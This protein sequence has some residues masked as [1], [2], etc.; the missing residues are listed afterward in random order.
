MKHGTQVQDMTRGSCM[1]HLLRFAFPL[2]CGSLLQ[3]LY[4][5]VDSWVVGRYVGDA[6]LAAV[7]MG[8][9][10]MLMYSS[11]FI[12]ISTGATVM[13]AQFF[14]AGHMEQTKDVV[15]TIYT[16]FTAVILPMTLLAAALVKPLLSLMRT[17]SE[18]LPDAFLYL[19]IIAVGSIGSLG[20]NLN[21]GI[22]QG[23]GNSRST[24]LFL[25]VASV[26]NILLDLLFVPVLGMGVEGVAIATIL[27]QLASWLAGVA[28]INKFYPEVRIHLFH[29]HFDRDLF[30]K[31][32]SIGLPHGLQMALVSFG[33]MLV[34]SQVNT[35]G[36]EFSA[37]YNVGT[38]VDNLSFLAVQAI[39]SAATA[40]T[41][42]NMGAERLDRVRT[43]V[44]DTLLLGVGWTALS[45]ALVVPLRDS[46]VG[47]FTDSPAAIEAGALYIRCILPYYG[48][49]AIMFCLNAVMRGA[50]ES[51]VPLLISVFGTILIRV[52]AVAWLAE[53]YGA[54]YMYY[55]YTIGHL[56][57]AVLAVAYY[58]SGRWKRKGSLAK[59]N[60]EIL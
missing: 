58:F 56:V 31:I 52:L 39:G 32:I 42:Q 49:F 17:D 57:A 7:G 18:V 23:L 16:T 33:I 40:F 5:M 2:L 37:G 51:I 6:A 55:G 43:G 9:P 20:Y 10:V 19:L 34:Y 46:I 13:I 41:G 38:K 45:A 47:L 27:S 15:D 3:Q 53:S 36:K 29:R 11:L 14:G 1:G 50:G 30:Q 28:Y 60:S 24:L 26:L 44:R 21:A 59:G 48:L 25:A 35:F 8:F 54:E 22:L 4:N 12:G